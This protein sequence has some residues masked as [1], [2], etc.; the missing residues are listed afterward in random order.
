MQSLQCQLHVTQS[1]RLFR[2][3]RATCPYRHISGNRI[4]PP[5]TVLLV[6]NLSVAAVDELSL[7]SRRIHQL[8][9]PSH[10]TTNETFMGS[11]QYAERRTTSLQLQFH[12]SALNKDQRSE[13]RRTTTMSKWS[14]L[15]SKT[16]T[17]LSEPVTA[18]RV[19][20]RTHGPLV[21]SHTQSW[22]LAA[23]IHG[24]G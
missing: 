21:P 19:R 24:F 15:S 14:L 17:V 1:T 16:V 9:G 20:Q 8:R 12:G 7:C 2:R 18:S 6:H 11:A 4:S 23:S 5:N 10:T 13:L 3:R 22:S